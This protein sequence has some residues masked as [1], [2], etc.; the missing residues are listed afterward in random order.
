MQTCANIDVIREVIRR[1][2]TWTSAAK[3]PATAP[4]KIQQSI[5]AAT[6]STSAAEHQQSH[7]QQQQVPVQLQQQQVPLQLQPL[8]KQLANRNS[9]SITSKCTIPTTIISWTN[10]SR[11]SPLSTGTIKAKTKSASSCIRRKYFSITSCLLN[12]DANNKDGFIDY[13]EFV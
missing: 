1:G 7:Y 10:L 9:S 11:S 3:V 4:T 6:I 8:P 2:G 13:P 12:A 5:S